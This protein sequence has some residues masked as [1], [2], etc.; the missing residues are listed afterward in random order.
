MTD[1]I[2]ALANASIGFGVSWAAT[3]WLLPAWGLHPT[4]SGSL[5]ITAM[6]FGLSLARSYGLRRAFRWMEART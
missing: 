1:A 4:A 5:G 6:F 3:Y 2:E